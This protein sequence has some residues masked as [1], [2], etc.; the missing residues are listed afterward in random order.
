MAS[1]SSH[2]SSGDRA[3][4]L[5][6]QEEA[7]WVTALVATLW[8]RQS[9]ASANNKTRILQISSLQLSHYAN[10]G[11]ISIMKPSDALF[12]Q[13]TENQ[14]PLHVSSI[15]CSSSG[16]TTWTALGILLV[17]NVSWLCHDSSCT[18]VKLQLWHSQLTLYASNIPSAVHVVPPEDE[19]VM[20][21]TCR[22]P[23]FSINWMKSASRW[24][25]YTDILWCTVNKTL[26]EVSC[27][28][29]PTKYSCLNLH[30]HLMGKNKM[31]SKTLSYVEWRNVSKLSVKKTI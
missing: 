17:Y 22:G 15:T 24:F 30:H 4:A 13:F 27:L 1:H 9:L 5:A 23:W 19:Q 20:L 26:S 2:F 31:V 7:G 11:I 16:G 25:H 12:I 6:E 14:E 18:A 3:P 10:W 8:K 21:E 28:C 29:T